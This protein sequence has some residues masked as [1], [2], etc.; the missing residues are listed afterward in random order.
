MAMEGLVCSRAFQKHITLRGQRHYIT[1]L[2]HAPPGPPYRGLG[3]LG[4]LPKEVKSFP[5]IF[6]S[7]V[8]RVFHQQYPPSTIKKKHILG[9]PHREG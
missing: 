1:P 4:G 3:G 2:S 6:D 7:L 8:V 5:K 9:L